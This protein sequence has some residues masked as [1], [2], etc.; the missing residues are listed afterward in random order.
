MFSAAKVFHYTVIKLYLLVDY[1]FCLSSIIIKYASNIYK[2]MYG[3]LK[4]HKNK[5]LY[6]S[7]YFFQKAND[8][9]ISTMWS[10]LKIFK[11][12]KAH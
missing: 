11:S 7:S 6:S 8:L 5:Q 9:F 1:G 2:K 3:F 10:Q 4:M 12:L